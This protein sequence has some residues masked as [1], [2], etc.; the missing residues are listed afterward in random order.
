MRC[1]RLYADTVSCI[2]RPITSE[3]GC[4]PFSLLHR[5]SCL[6]SQN[7]P[8]FNL[9]TLV[10]LVVRTMPSFLL[11]PFLHGESMVVEHERTIKRRNRGSCHFGWVRVPYYRARC[12][13]WYDYLVDSS[14][15]GTY[16]ET[17]RRCCCFVSKYLNKV[18]TF[19]SIIVRR[20]HCNI[21]SIY[22]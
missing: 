7:A 22:I 17:V 12:V 10:R 21:R 16:V 1:F 15:T 9:S 13:L 3:T 20:S 11:H 5:S 2:L 19:C 4:S 6:G 18:S 8:C 14:K